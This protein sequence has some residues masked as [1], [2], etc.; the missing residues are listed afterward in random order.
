MQQGPCWGQLY[1][2]LGQVIPLGEETK[3]LCGMHPTS[4]FSPPRKDSFPAQ[5]LHCGAGPSN[6][7]GWHRGG[8]GPKEW[9]WVQSGR[10]VGGQDPEQARSP[11]ASLPCLSCRGVEGLGGNW[12]LPSIMGR[13]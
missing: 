3:A 1:D 4:P 10:G 6:Q 11:L 12:L 13:T 7:W 8:G 9:P 5:R 2:E